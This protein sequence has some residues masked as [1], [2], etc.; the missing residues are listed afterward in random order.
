MEKFFLTLSNNAV[1]L[2]GFVSEN[3]ESVTL[4]KPYL[5]IND[6]GQILLL[7]Y[8]VDVLNQEIENTIFLKSNIINVIEADSNTSLVRK[9]TETI[10][11]IK[12]GEEI[13][14][15]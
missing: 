4:S 15:G 14:L 10:T 9:Y 1:V 2:G 13:I 12:T 11:G 7:P 6:G 3:S 8:L 5:V